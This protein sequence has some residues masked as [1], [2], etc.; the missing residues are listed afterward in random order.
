MPNNSRYSYTYNHSKSPNAVICID[1]ISMKN[2][3][4]KWLLEAKAKSL[5]IV[6]RETTGSDSE[7]YLRNKFSDWEIVNLNYPLRTTKTISEKVKRGQVFSNIHVNSF[8]KSL[9]V[10]I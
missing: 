2:V 10:S 7:E 1:E 3:E 8:N 4:P 9:K 5:W 6:I